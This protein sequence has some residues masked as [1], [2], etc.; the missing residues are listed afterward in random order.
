LLATER[1]RVSTKSGRITETVGS[2]SERDWA[3]A[4]RA[5]GR[6]E[7]PDE[8]VRAIETY[9]VDKPNP[10]YYAER[11]VAKAETYRRSAASTDREVCTGQFRR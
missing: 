9:R 4:L 7:Q 3:F 1:L 10:R 5:L 2:Q 6:G 11:T 8:I